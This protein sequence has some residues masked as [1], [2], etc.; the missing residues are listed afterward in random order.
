[1]DRELLQTRVRRSVVISLVLTGVFLY[2]FVGAVAAQNPIVVENGQPG[3]SGWMIPFSSTATDSQGQ[4]KGYASATS[5]NK[6]ENITFYVSVQPAQSYVIDIYRM[7]WYQGLGGR[8]M[9]HIGSLNG[10]PQPICPTDATTGEIECNWAPAYIL[11]TQ[12]SWTS[13]VY[14]AQ[15]TNS[16]GFQNYIEFV[17]RD[18]SRVAALLYQQPVTTYQAYNDYPFDNQTGKSLYA[19]NSYGATTVSGGANAVKVSFDRPYHGDG[20]GN[21]WG[22]TFFIWEFPFVRWMEKSGYDVTYATDIDTHTNGGMLLNYLG[23]LS[24]GHDEYWS[25][26]MYDAFIAARDAGVNL[27]FFSANRSE[28]QTRLESSSIGVSNR[29]VVCYRNAPLDPITDPTLKTVEWRDPPLNRPEQTLAGVQF[30]N[31]T[32]W[33]PQTGGYYPYVVANSGNW[34]YAGTGFEDGDSVPGIVG[35]EADRWFSQYPSPPVVSGTYTLL[36]NSP[37]TTSANTSDFS[38]ASVYQAPSGAWVFAAGTIGWSWALDN[39]GGHNVLDTRIQQTTTNVLNRFVNPASNFAIAASPSSQTV[40]AGGARSYS[41]AISPTGGF[42]GQVTLSVSGLPS[43]ANGSFSPN[44][45]SSS[46]T[47]SVTTSTSTLAGT[48]TLTISGVSG[49]LTHS[50][51]VA[52]VVNGPPDF[53]LSASPS[54]QTVTQGGTTTYNVT[55]TAIGGFVGQVT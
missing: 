34:V 3:T 11:N 37:F 32:L 4:I 6:G 47:L 31:Q 26:P 41:V 24:V 28:W 14:L 13:G 49:G 53:L 10:S 19:F 20:T 16:Q 7:G 36:S 21:K 15:L 35:Y 18:D 9:Q 2:V 5:V 54:S 27:G 25:R 48:Y 38:N 43:G 51:T 23:I 40:T 50:T 29:V 42:S 33:T 1:M 12:T 45:A 17:L 30:V 8:L 22:Q 44:P 55:I 52:L 39:F 46:A